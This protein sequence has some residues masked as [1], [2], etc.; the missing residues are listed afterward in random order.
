MVHQPTMTSTE[1]YEVSEPLVF[2]TVVDN[3][4]RASGETR[5][6]LAKKIRL[7]CSTLLK[8]R[9]LEPERGKIHWTSLVMIGVEM[10]YFE[11]GEWVREDDPRFVQ[12]AGNLV[13]SHGRGAPHFYD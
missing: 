3:Y 9:A 6:Q 13:S 5:A 4:V 11:Y 2:D 7:S 12:L 8:G 1:G 10:G